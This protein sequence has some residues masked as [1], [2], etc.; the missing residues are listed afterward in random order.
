[1]ND[2]DFDLLSGLVT[3][4]VACDFPGAGRMEGRRRTILLLQSIFRKY[5]DL[6]FRV[7]E[8]LSDGDR[9]CVVWTN[10]GH[11]VSGDPYANSGMTLLYFTEDRISFISD[12]FKDTSFIS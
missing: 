2:R 4:M 9:A 11:T 10:V 3:D 7:L 6:K 12:Y 5:P 8:V 1:M